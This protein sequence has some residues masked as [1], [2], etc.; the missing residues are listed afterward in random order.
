[1]SVYFF[2][3]LVF[4]SSFFV[5]NFTFD[6][7]IQKRISSYG[8]L[9]LGCVLCVFLGGFRWHTGTDW[10]SYSSF[11]IQNGSFSQ[12]N[13]GTF[14]IGWV[15][16]NWA[17][18]KI[19]SSYTVYL[20][21]FHLLTVAINC[22][23]VARYLK[24]AEFDISLFGFLYFTSHRG[25]IFA[26]RQMLSCAILFLAFSFLIEKQNKKFFLFVLLACSVHMT[27]IVFIFAPYISKIKL[28]KFR[29]LL[30]IV[31]SV[32]LCFYGRNIL[33]KIFLFFISFL[34]A[35]RLL[36][37]FVSYQNGVA[38]ISPVLI[39]RYLFFIPFLYFLY[40]NSS[41]TYKAFFNNYLVGCLLFIVTSGIMPV[42]QR[43]ALYYTNFEAILI[44]LY[45]RKLKLKRCKNFIICIFLSYACLKYVT[46]FFG[47]Y[48]NLYVPYYSVFSYTEEPVRIK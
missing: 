42:L 36:G 29:V 1:M 25:D 6:R 27:S 19:C 5:L 47:E 3:L 2:L 46:S 24:I 21:I 13:N 23:A 39:V 33:M 43:F 12:F 15:I 32:A 40:S 44:C 7:G 18:K 37:K 14:E 20:L 10:Y 38:S 30:L 31:L 17:I 9:F 45:M 34:P 35:G 41:S 16:L 8:F 4:F 11:F 28:K 48:H 22:I 26:T